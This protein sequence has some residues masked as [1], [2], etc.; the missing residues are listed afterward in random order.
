MKFSP[1]PFAALLAVLLSCTGD[2][3]TETGRAPAQFQAASGSGQAG[4]VGTALPAPLVVRTTDARGRAMRGVA[5]TWTTSNGGG[6]LSAASGVTDAAGEARAQWTLGTAPGEHAV[7]ATVQGTAPVVFTAVATPGAPASLRIAAGDGQTGI[8]GTAP[9]PAPAVRVADSYGNPLSGVEVAWV[10][11]A[12]GGS[13]SPAASRTDA[14]GIASVRWVLG[15]GVGAHGLAATAGGLPAAAFTRTATPRPVPARVEKSG[16]GQEATVGEPLGDSL[17]VRVVSADGTRVPGV[18][19]SWT[20][21]EGT[22]SSP[23]GPTDDAGNA[24]VRWTL[25]GGAGSQAVEARVAGLDGPPVVFRASARTGPTATLKKSLG[26]GQHGSVGMELPIPLRVEAADR[27]GN[28]VVGVR[29]TWTAGQGGSVTSEIRSTYP[30]GSAVGSWKLGPGEGPQTAAVTV[31]GITAQFTATAGP[32]VPVASIALLPSS[33][34]TL[35]EGYPDY[36]GATVRDAAGNPLGGRAISWSSSR[37]EVASLR[38]TGPGIVLVTPLAPGTTTITASAE[39]RSASLVATVTPG[40]RLKGLTLT[41]ASVDVTSAPATVEFTIAA[42]DAGPGIADAGVDLE[43]PAGGSRSWG[44][45]ASTPAS[46]TP[47]DGVWKC[48]VTLPQGMTVGNMSIRYLVFTNR[49]GMQ[50]AIPG[51]QVE[52]AGFPITVA[53]RNSAVPVARPVLTGLT[54]SPATVDVTRSHGLIEFMAT[55]S[56]G[57]DV[58][59]VVV[60]ASNSPYGIAC[61]KSTLVSGTARSGT[62]KCPLQVPMSV[63]A[64]TWSVGVSIGDHSG[65]GRAYDSAMLQAAGFPGTFVVTRASADRRARP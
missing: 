59:S 4:T 48:S 65:G 10:V 25:G 32:V 13:V 42:T 33:S 22:L 21:L 14:A 49:Q 16:D 5:V 1:L 41:P 28:P 53:I 11:T 46:G 56:A 19:V 27:F 34:M 24:R 50:V 54:F 17:I 58:R 8:V 18:M 61:E 40:P 31:E 57:A 29:A 62:W 30:G 12:G 45:R 7:T 23:S 9:S 2:S 35:A 60:M 20:A 51:Y 52:Q 44:C 6:T 47:A 36:I 39:G 43:V 63:P 38:S 37:P 64:G 55:V 3:P 26:D 15:P